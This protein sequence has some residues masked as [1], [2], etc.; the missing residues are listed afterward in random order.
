MAY[1]EDFEDVFTFSP[2]YQ[3]DGQ[4]CE[5]IRANRKQMSNTLFVDR[6]LKVL[7]V[8]GGRISRVAS[9]SS[10]MTLLTS[11]PVIKFYP[12]KTNQ[13]LRTLHQRII[14]TNAQDHYKQSIIY[15]LIKDCARLGRHAKAEDIFVARSH[16]PAKY[17]TFVD[18]LWHLDHQEAE[19]A[20]EYLT[21]PSLT[22][23]FPDEILLEL[24]KED[25]STLP[26]AYY[27]TVSPP[28]T[29]AKVRDAFFGVLCRTSVH[30]AFFFA[31][32]QPHPTRKTLFEQL[33]HIVH[34]ERNRADSASQLVN[35]PLDE[36]EDIWFEDYL[37]K[38]I[39][40]HEEHAAD[41]VMMR[42][43][44]LGNVSDSSVA[45]QGL[46]RKKIN[47]IGWDELKIGLEQGVPQNTRANGFV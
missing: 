13:D 42:R 39:D 44:A 19:K 12:P 26:M 9:G 22:P 24:C 36:D 7:G 2:G 6:L 35:L 40:H 23:S 45:I 31:R 43:I 27:Y 18:G 25:D 37:T 21:D 4:V 33:L 8:Q 1:H 17:R 47:G 11:S 10:L 14:S 28:L 30:E 29:D 20:L 34:T 38:G 32:K 5:K 3:Y 46:S 41:T 15:Y 16:L